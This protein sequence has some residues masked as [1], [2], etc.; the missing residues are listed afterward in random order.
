M[1]IEIWK[2][3]K[4]YE[5]LYQVSSE[6]RVKSLNY[7]RTREEK[8]LKAG[9]QQ[10]GYQHV[11]LSKEGKVTTFRVHRLVC[12]AFKNLDINDKKAVILHRDNNPSNNTL[13]NLEVGDQSENILQAFREGRKKASHLGKF[14]KDN[15][16][17]KEIA[18]FTLEDEFIRVWPS[19][20]NASR[21]LKINH[22][23]ISSCC[24]GK[25]KSAGGFKWLFN[26]CPLI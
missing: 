22:G 25:H 7:K 4:G 14:G 16:L 2:D 8:I 19:M 18:Q 6:G 15:H 13:D 17:S 9:I 24:T 5:G 12:Q 21:E 26:I 3:I 1:E 23:N 11:V 20:I 10:Q